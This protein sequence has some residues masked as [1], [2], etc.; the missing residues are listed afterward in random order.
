MTLTSTLYMKALDA[1]PISTILVDAQQH[2]MPI[3]YSNPAFEHLTG[4]ALAEIMGQNCRFLQADD[5]DQPAIDTIR[6]ALEAG[7]ACTTTLRNYRKDGTLFWNELSL[8][9]IRD[10]NG[11]ITHFIGVQ[12]DVT[13]QVQAEDMLVK[14]EELHRITLSSISE[15]VLITNDAGRFTYICPNVSNIFGFD[16]DDFGGFEDI[17]AVLGSEVFNLERLKVVGEI[18]NIQRVVKNRRGDTIVL[19]ITVKRVDIMGGTILYT[20]RDITERYEIEN[21]LQESEY[22]YRQMFE[23]SRNVMLLVDPVTSQIIDANPAAADFYGYSQQQLWQMKILDI[24]T[25]PRDELFQKIDQV[26]KQEQNFFQ[27]QH[28]LA[29]GEVRDVE[30]HAV[31]IVYKQQP[32]LYSSIMDV[33]ERNRTERAL[34]ESEQRLLGVLNSSPDTIYMLNLETRATSFFNRSEFLGYSFEELNRPG[35]IFHAI[36]PDDQAM[37]GRE[38]QMLLESNSDQI[39]SLEYRVQRKTGEWEWLHMRGVII[40]RTTDGKPREILNTITVVTPRKQMEEDLRR[41]EARNRALLDA[42]PDLLFR[43]NRDGIIVDYKPSSDAALYAPPEFFLNKHISEVYP[44]HIEESI[45]ILQRAYLSGEVQ[46]V[47]YI[48]P[49]NGESR[50]YESRVTAIGEDETLSVIRDI[51]DVKRA[52]EAEK[53]R[54]LLKLELEKEREIHELKSRF[55]S[56]A[57]HDFRSPLSVILSSSDLL[58]YYTQNISDD[59]LAHV[60]RHLDK[61]KYSVEHMTDLLDDVLLLNKA[62]AGRLE[63]HPVPL[64]LRELCQELI[65]EVRQTDQDQHHFEFLFNGTTPVIPGDEKLLRQIITN[66]L[67]NAVKY[68]EPG[69]T[70]RVQLHAVGASITLEIQDEGI[71]IPLKDQAKLFEAFHRASNVGTRQGTG[72]GLSIVKVAAEAHG[73]TVRCESEVDKGTMFTITLPAHLPVSA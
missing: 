38:W 59:V 61:I 47:E 3:I 41:S 57:S 16:V 54:A 43:V 50:V 65:D 55:I 6:R 23:R 53:E 34:R 28:R 44:N 67:S 35:S 2:D 4:Y 60:L 51:T 7:E 66:L 25:L 64:D 62:N 71:G 9:P 10:E 15:A 56:M 12:K 20:C 63:F 21:E 19:L 18:S 42:I 14:S 31:P 5:R 46:T 40:S 1:S 36:H 24:N 27:F 70:V 72:L 52:R 8:S 32:V 39:H 49:V 69:T 11:A 45:E 17:S 73:G 30:V 68:A 26:Q 29:S 13:R 22:R 58:R 37:V 33:T 48:Y